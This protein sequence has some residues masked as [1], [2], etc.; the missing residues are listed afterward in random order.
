MAPLIDKN[1]YK[2]MKNTK[3]VKNAVFYKDMFAF[4]DAY[5][6]IANLKP[7]KLPN[8]CVLKNNKLSLEGICLVMQNYSSELGFESLKLTLEYL[9]VLYYTI[10]SY[11][12]NEFMPEKKL[13]EDEFNAYKNAS[14][15]LSRS[16][17]AKYEEKLKE[18]QNVKSD[19]DKTSS[20]YAK[21]II[22]SRI[23]SGLAVVLLILSFFAGM[24]PFVFYYFEMLS[25]VLTCVTAGACVVV[26]FAVYMLLKKY[27]EKL[28][29]DSSGLLYVIQNKKKAKNQAY[30]A[31]NE[32]KARY[33]K[34]ASEKYGYNNSFS[35]EIQKFSSKLSMEEVLKKASEYKLLSYNFK[36]DIETL[37]IN[38]ENEVNQ[39]LSRIESA[40]RASDYQKYLAECYSNIKS[41][42]WLYYNN[43]IRLAFIKKFAEISEKTFNWRLELSGEKINPFGINIK[44]M[45]KEQVTF[46]N[47]EDSLFIS[48]SLDS[49]LKNNYIKSLSWLKLK[50]LNNS[51][52]IKNAKAEFML[53]FFDYDKTKI[54]DNLFYDKKLSDGAKISND[55]IES[56]QKIPT[57][58][59]ATLKLAERYA[60]IE[61]CDF[62]IIS[63]ITSDISEKESK[64]SGTKQEDVLVINESNIDYPDFEC[65]S[66][67]DFGEYIKY[68]I[69][70]SSF[71]GYKFT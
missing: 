15:E 38:Q 35:K 44:E 13:I 14:E 22:G 23:S 4:Y 32:F 47:S 37:F 31:M 29:S 26:G 8:Y 58:I 18:Y 20:E 59:Y 17:R 57:F 11:S 60:G 56:T 9:K 27:S 52:A 55:I 67:E 49:L 54:Y 21:K 68:N 19:F 70:G 30:D 2:V 39:V 46:L 50:N 3:F 71:I 69:G 10:A 12:N 43:Q 62:E 53:H 5:S 16:E 65:D 63:K 51:V 34:I 42:D 66:T 33:A 61:N 36:V 64:I 41:K 25:F 7:A 1:D 6:F 40:D 28:E 48:A 45:A 24:F